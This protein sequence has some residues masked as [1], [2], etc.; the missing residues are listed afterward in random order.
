VT[1]GGSVFRAKQLLTILD[2][3][4][5][6][7]YEIARRQ[8]WQNDVEVLFGVQRRMADWGYLHAGSW[9]ELLAVHDQWVADYNYQDHFAHQE[10][11]ED[12]RISASLG[13]HADPIARMEG[14][15]GDHRRRHRVDLPGHQRLGMHVHIVFVPICQPTSGQ[16][17][18]PPVSTTS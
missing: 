2:R 11:P 3:L 8:A 15:D 16:R 5:I 1:D 17:Y 9:S 13:D 12:R 6:Q 14:A 18:C 10:R 7:K 4:G